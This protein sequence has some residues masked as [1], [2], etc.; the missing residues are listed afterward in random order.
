AFAG[1]VPDHGLKQFA[2]LALWG[3]LLDQVVVV[4]RCLRMSIVEVEPTSC[5]PTV[6]YEQRVDQGIERRQLGAWPTDLGTADRDVAR[7]VA[8]EL[9]PGTGRA[10]EVEP[11]VR[12]GS[13]HRPDDAQATA[14]ARDL[15]VGAVRFVRQLFGAGFHLRACFIDAVVEVD[16]A[17]VGILEH[18]ADAVGVAGGD[19]GDRVGVAAPGGRIVRARVAS[20]VARLARRFG[21]LFLA[22]LGCAQLPWPNDPALLFGQWDK[23]GRQVREVGVLGVARVRRERWIR[24]TNPTCE[25]TRGPPVV[26]P[27]HIDRHVLHAEVAGLDVNEQR[28]RRIERAK[29]ARL[30]DAGRANDQSLHATRLG[31]PL[32]CAN[33][34][35]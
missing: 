2:A 27:E 12:L 35:H 4:E 20:R 13:G 11:A 19:R 22:A 6:A 28:A 5:L 8:V 24:S 23:R 25:I 30:A 26:Q 1:H 29:Q 34:L 15:L 31:E 3:A 14:W 32:I 7:R 33:D 17:N 16:G 10:V 9:D 21:P 18:V